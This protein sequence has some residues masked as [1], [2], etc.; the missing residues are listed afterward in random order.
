M[1]SVTLLFFIL[2]VG[3]TTAAQ[4]KVP[5]PP[6]VASDIIQAASQCIL[7]SGVN[8]DLLIKFT[9]FDGKN[10][11][12]DEQLNKFAYCTL[13]KT[14]YGKR[15]GR[16]KLDK[17]IAVMPNDVDIDTVKKVMEKCNEET[18]KDAP[19]TTFRVFKCLSEKSPVLMT[20]I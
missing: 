18:G 14:G 16:L 2:A 15:D 12:E 6:D 20:M 8:P 19:Q 10:V 9:N 11:A 5:F 1:R 13:L 7:E 4:R 17:A 3:L